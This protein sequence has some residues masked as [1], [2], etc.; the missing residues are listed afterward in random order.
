MADAEPEPLTDEEAAAIVAVLHDHRVRFVVIGGF[1]VQLHEVSGLARTSDIDITPER[2]RANLERLAEA[3]TQL[4]A[5][6]RE[7]GLPDEGLAV[8]WHADLL[9]RMDLAA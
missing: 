1:A 6:L 3:L 9:E 5:R 8:P 2:S 7:D 4:N